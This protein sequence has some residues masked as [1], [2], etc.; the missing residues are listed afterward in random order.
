V[1][2]IGLRHQQGHV[3]LHAVVARIRDHG[4][5][6][7]RESALDFVAPRRPWPE[8]QL[9]R[10]AARLFDREVR[11]VAGMTPSRRQLVAS[12][13]FFP[14]LRSLAPAHFISNQGYSVEK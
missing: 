13:Y 9:G 1:I 12:R 3:G 7:R 8:Q 14:V 4:V 11:H 10:V 6:R 2:G 5:T